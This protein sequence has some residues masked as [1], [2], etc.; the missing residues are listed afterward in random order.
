MSF[1][2]GEEK[3]GGKVLGTG[4]RDIIIYIYIYDRF[5][6]YGTKHLELNRDAFKSWKRAKNGSTIR[7]HLAC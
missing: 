5:R 3:Y 4:Y 1:A 6:L 2:A 7:V